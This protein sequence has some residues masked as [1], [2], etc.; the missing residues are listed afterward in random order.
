MEGEYDYVIAREFRSTGYSDGREATAAV[1]NPI[2]DKID[3]IIQYANVGYVPLF[4]TMLFTTRR[5]S[6]PPTVRG[7]R[8]KDIRNKRLHHSP[9]YPIPTPCA[10]TGKWRHGEN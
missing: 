10:S 8:L 1:T 4:L 9:P 5:W 3:A 2:A 6:L 7:P